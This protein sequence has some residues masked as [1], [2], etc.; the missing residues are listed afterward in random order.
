MLRSLALVIL[1][2]AT[3]AGTSQA[4]LTEADLLEEVDVTATP[5]QQEVEIDRYAQKIGVVS[6]RQIEDLN[7]QD[8]TQAL[9][10]VPGVIISRYNVTGAYG[11]REG[12]ALFIR[13]HGAGRP[14]AEISTMVDGI[15]RF[16]GVWTHPVMDILSVD[17]VDQI[18]V[19]K[20]AQP[21]LFGNMAFAAVNVI[22]KR[23][24]QE[25]FESRLYAGYGTYDS[26]VALAEHGGKID[27]FDYYFVGSHRES[28]GHRKHADGEVDSL[29]GR[30]GYQLDEHWDLS[31]QLAHTEGWAHDPRAK[32]APPIPIAEEFGTDNELYILTVSHAYERA[33]GFIKLYYEDGEID[34]S[35]Y[36]AAVPEVWWSRTDYDNYG[37]RVQEKLHL[38]EGGEIVLGYDHDLYGGLSREDRPS[39]EKGRSDKH[40]RN[41][42]PYAMVSHTFGDAWRFTPS[43][44]LRYNDSRDFDSELGWQTGATLTHDDT[45]FYAN[46]AR[47][48]NYPG[49]FAATYFDAFWNRPGQWR[50]L[51][52]ET[53][54]HYEIGVNHRFTDW[55]GVDVSFFHDEVQDALRFVPPPPPPPRYANVG[56]YEMNGLE[57]N[58][59]ITPMENL[60]IFTGATLNDTDPGD[61]PDI[62]DWTWVA[63]VSY[64]WRERV[65]INLDA[66]YI[67]E[68]EVLNPR[69]AT[70][71][72]EVASYTLVNARVG[73]RVTPDDWRMSGEFFVAAEN[74]G[75][76]EYEVRPDYPMPGSTY[77]LGVD[78]RY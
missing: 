40:F 11:G 74:I 67:D 56:D 51:N 2:L 71:Q 78:L 53:L 62:P 49:V 55:F 36:D 42:A 72:D 21:V 46:Y 41:R 63:G 13:G 58:I 57:A 47:A 17:Y 73:V 24:T 14:G 7:A 60:E 22:P 65:R 52:A 38:W 31:L 30:I 69:Y 45:T 59:N 64:T 61:V 15:P 26:W 9:R 1:G 68:M 70:L 29:Y 43:A 8:L 18:D 77:M 23:R 75:D 44:G 19:Y 20:S 54:D 16:V 12:G 76:E 25:G 34:W 35:Q 32:D 33:E 66:Q 3:L 50:D 5:I 6:D 27:A 37:V 28:A 10:R 4:D 48:F 39:G